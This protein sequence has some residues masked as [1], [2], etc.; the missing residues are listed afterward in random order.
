MSQGDVLC[1]RGSNIESVLDQVIL[2]K[3]TFYLDPEV[4]SHRIGGVMV[5]VLASSARRS[6]VRAPIG[7]NQRL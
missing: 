6:W 2:S 7:S 4:E 3:F 5:S 1:F